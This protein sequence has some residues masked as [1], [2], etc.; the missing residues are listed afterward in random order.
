MIKKSVAQQVVHRGFGTGLCINALH[1]NRT[2]KAWAWGAVWQWF[3]WHGARN[4]NGVRRNFT[5]ENLTGVT[6][7][8]LGGRGDEHAHRQY[9]TFAHD[10]AFN[11][12]RTRANEA[13]VFNDNRAS[14]KRLKNTTNANTA[15]K[16]NVF[17]DLAQEPT[18]TQVSTMVPSST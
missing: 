4:N 12:F 9:C 10:H 7:D 3:T 5:H 11:N 17:A 14:L 13:V 18:V 16:V 15:G 8:D 1:N 6:V 2:G